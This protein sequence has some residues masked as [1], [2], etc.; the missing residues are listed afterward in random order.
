[1]QQV[2]GEQGEE[3]VFSGSI[4]RIAKLLRE[5]RAEEIHHLVA[6]DFLE[7]FQA[8]RK[9]SDSPA[10][11]TVRRDDWQRLRDKADDYDRM[12]QNYQD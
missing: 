6:A 12:A 2:P 9:R 10:W 11:I 4:L 7:E 8:L 1:M 5:G 3:D